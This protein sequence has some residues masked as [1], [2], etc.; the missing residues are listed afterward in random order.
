MKIGVIVDG[1]AEQYS[2]GAFYERIETQSTIFKPLYADIQPNSNPKKIL[3]KAL[4]VIR[5][6]A[7]KDVDRVII[8]LDREQRLDCVPLWREQLEALIQPAAL[9][10][11][12]GEAHIVLKDRMFENW[13]VSDVTVFKKL[14]G[15][16]EFTDAHVQQVSPNKADRV[17]ATKLLK[18][19]TKRPGY[20]KVNDASKIMNHFDPYQGAS[21]SRSL[22]RFLRL[23]G[24]SVYADNSKLVQP[25]V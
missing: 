19:V 23:L 18:K 25:P 21:N 16:F 12:V 11:G 20:H 13:L 9:N 5:I 22:R 1:Q 15:R 6:L 14:R 8:C 24:C 3:R 4:P 10:E 2:L 7:K 17:D